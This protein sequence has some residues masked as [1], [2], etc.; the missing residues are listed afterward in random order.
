MKILMLA[1]RDMKHP[2]KGGAE[3]VTDIYLSKL[4]KLNHDVTLFTASYSNAEKEETYNNYKIIRKGNS[5]T[6]S[7]HGLRYAKK[8]EKNFDIIIDQINTIPFFTPLFIKKQ[9]RIAFFHQL[10]KNIWFYEKSF[11]VSLIGYA[12]ESLYLKLYANT[13]AFTISKSSKQDLIKYAWINPSNILVLENQIDFQPISKPKEKANYLVFVGRLTTSKRVHDCIKALALMQ[14]ISNVNNKDKLVS[15]KNKSQNNQQMPKLSDINITDKNQSVF[16]ISKTKLVIIGNGNEK[17]KDY[18]KK[19]TSKLNLSNRVLFT[20]SIDSKKRNK[21][22]Q[23]ALAIL[24]TSVRE[25]WGLIVTE[26]NANGTIAITYNTQGLVDANTN[27][28]GIITKNNTPKELAKE[29]NFII[30]NPKL[31]KQKE[32]KALEFAREH[33]DWDKQARRLEEWIKNI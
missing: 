26:A 14:N 2:K 33:S 4:A 19:L 22:M 20:G 31:R 25:G 18:L 23:H 12:L 15:S 3:I 5:I 21:I 28:T 13:K 29:I 10:C 24:V 6:V 17:Y 7:M 16:D 27:Q 1:W 32:V 9:K 30:N 8:N 11:P